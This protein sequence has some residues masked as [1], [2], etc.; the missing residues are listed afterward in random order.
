VLCY[1]I[2]PVALNGVVIVVYGPAQHKQSEE[3]LEELNNNNINWRLV[4]LF[5]EFI[6]DL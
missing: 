1:E 5:D 4:D 6:A 3:F 2:N